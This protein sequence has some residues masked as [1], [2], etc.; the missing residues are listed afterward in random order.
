MFYVLNDLFFNVRID[1]VRLEMIKKIQLRAESTF[2]LK[3]LKKR[4]KRNITKTPC[5]KRQ[6]LVFFTKISKNSD[7]IIYYRGFL[8]KEE[9]YY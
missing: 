5:G 8:H 9:L 2:Y 1:K 6:N 7:K 3:K 4:T